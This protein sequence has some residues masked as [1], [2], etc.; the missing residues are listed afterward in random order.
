MP[1]PVLIPFYKNRTQ[2]D[3]CLAA[4]AAQDMPVEP[5]VHDNS[6]TNLYFTVAQN[7][8][9]KRAMRHGHEFAVLLTQDCYLRPDA[10]SK[11]VA[12]MRGH[13]RCAIGGIKQVLAADQDRIIHGGCSTA[14]PAG[15]HYA[16]RKSL[17]HCAVSAR[18]PWVN[19]AC[20][21]ARLEAVVEFGLMDA[22]M[23]MVG[24]DSDWCFTARARGW[25]V[26]YCADAEAAHEVGI[27]ARMPP[28]DIFAVCRADMVY[29]RDKWVGTALYARLE[30]E[31]LL[32][33]A[34]TYQL[35]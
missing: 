6:E 4:L 10:V 2:L 23:R 7:L 35:K 3:R 29:W 12:F 8:G 21:V 25:E 31:V 11:M 14:F 33:P 32:P 18:M 34:F 20:M 22:N 1:V 30:S 26:W 19:G 27:S 24:S 9:L 5:W 13:P 28:P 15:R 17:G 16:G